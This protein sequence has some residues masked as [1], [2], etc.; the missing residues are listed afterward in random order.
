MFT[1]EFKLGGWGRGGASSPCP[2]FVAL[3]GF[4]VR[5]TGSASQQVVASWRKAADVAGQ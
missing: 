5:K 4:L 1:Y 3:S 2:N